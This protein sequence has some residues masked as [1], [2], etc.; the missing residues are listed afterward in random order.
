MKE[1]RA[2]ELEDVVAEA[3]LAGVARAKHK[4]RAALRRR[5]GDQRDGRGAVEGR[6]DVREHRLSYVAVT[7]GEREVREGSR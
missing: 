6:H 7:G 4:R 3:E 2:P 5:G 1:L